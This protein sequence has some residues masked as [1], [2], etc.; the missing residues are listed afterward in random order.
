MISREEME[1][2]I[3]S[4]RAQRWTQALGP[5]RIVPV[6]AHMDGAWWVVLDG[7]DGFQP[8]PGPLADVLDAVSHALGQAHDA[9]RRARIV[10]A[11]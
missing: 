6:A 4:G 1:Q 2:F 11:S 8:A 5:D 10:R 3:A 7:F 9:E